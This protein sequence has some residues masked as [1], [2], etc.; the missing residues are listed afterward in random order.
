MGEGEPEPE[1]GEDQQADHCWHVSVTRP[2]LQRDGHV[3]ST[4]T[5]GRGGGEGVSV[6]VQ[7][8]MML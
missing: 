6:M 7:T 3:T 2:G 5:E 1:L 4:W 8:Y